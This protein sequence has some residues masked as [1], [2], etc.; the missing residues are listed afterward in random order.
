MK[1]TDS[2]PPSAPG[3]DDD[4]RARLV[5]PPKRVSL[6]SRLRTYLL[7]G[8]IV[9]APLAITIYLAWAFIVTV[10]ENVTPL[11]PARYNPENYLPFTVPGLGI[12][13]VSIGFII[14]GF[15]TANFVGRSL[16]RT[17]ERMVDRMPVVRTVY[18]ALKQIFET[19]LQQSSQ[20]FSQVVLIEYP[21]PGSWAIAFLTADT[22]GEVPRKT[23]R[24][25]I[26][27]FVPTTPNP[28]SGFV[29]FVPREDVIFL[30]MTVEEG[31]K[32]V[33]SAGMVM[34]PDRTAPGYVPPITPETVR[35]RRLQARNNRN[36]RANKA[37]AE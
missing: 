16:I 11:I 6:L 3:A 31:M 18:S 13:V 37:A 25:L 35:A 29:L 2:P 15:L 17:G 14:I 27:L 30:D 9:T 28:T 19:V 36:N 1:K 5:R 20:A 26:S 24:D 10:D 21:R 22:L 12:L 4:D 33:I 7:T 8:L 34:P 23:E 32:M